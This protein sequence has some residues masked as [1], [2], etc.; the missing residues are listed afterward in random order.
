MID[1]ILALPDVWTPLSTVVPAV[2]GEFMALDGGVYVVLSATAPAAGDVGGYEVS[3]RQMD[4]RDDLASLGLR[5]WVKP[6]SGLPV[7]VYTKSV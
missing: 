4:R 7:T 6:I 3:Q 5:V 2:M 1:R